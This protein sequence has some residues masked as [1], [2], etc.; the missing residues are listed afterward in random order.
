MELLVEGLKEYRVL[1]PVRNPYYLDVEYHVL[2]FNHPAHLVP[3]QARETD[4]VCRL[5]FDVSG[6]HCVYDEMQKQSF[7]TKE[8]RQFLQDLKD[9]LTILDRYMLDIRQVDFEPQH[10][11]RDREEGFCW[12]YLPIRSE[13]TVKDI[14]NL[15]QWV[16]TVIDYNDHDM[17]QFAYHTYWYVRSHP[18]SEKS[19]QACMDYQPDDKLTAGAESYE[20]FFNQPEELSDYSLPSDYSYAGEE[21][22]KEETTFWKKTDRLFVLEIFAGVMVAACLIIFAVFMVTAILNRQLYHMK[23]IL[24]GCLLGALLF[25]DLCY[26]IRKK[27]RTRPPAAGRKRR[28]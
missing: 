28:W 9:L 20:E 8:F 16:M 26:R 24:A 18:F 10:I 7:S 19:L 3:V 13:D 27:E 5:L 11:Y 23:Y 2:C 14:E 21:E 4:G 6:L 22:R 15:F 25:T 12:F 1:E 17:I